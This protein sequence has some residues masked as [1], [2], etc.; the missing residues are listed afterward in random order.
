MDAWTKSDTA[1]AMFLKTVS[2]RDF[3]EYE[4]RLW[5]AARRQIIPLREKATA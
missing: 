2:E 3:S 4:F 5:Q 1:F